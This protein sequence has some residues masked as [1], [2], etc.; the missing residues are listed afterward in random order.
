MYVHAWRYAQYWWNESSNNPKRSIKFLPLESKRDKNKHE[1]NNPKENLLEQ[2]LLKPDPNK[3]QQHKKPPLDPTQKIR[4]SL[5]AS[6]IRPL[7]R[8][9]GYLRFLDSR[10]PRENGIDW[11]WLWIDGT[12]IRWLIE[13]TWLVIN[14]LNNILLVIRKLNK[15]ADEFKPSISSPYY[16]PNQ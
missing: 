8:R 3:Q 4:Q 16:Y 10:W 13:H 12:I 14:I 9:L 11:S 7:V 5:L 6:S 2:H 15:S 1:P